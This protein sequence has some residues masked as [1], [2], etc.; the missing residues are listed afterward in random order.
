MPRRFRK[1]PE[2]SIVIV[3]GHGRVYDAD[4]VEGDRYA[5]FAPHLLREIGVP[6]P[7]P[8][9]I[10]VPAPVAA[11][12]FRDALVQATNDTVPIPEEPA[13]ME[14]VAAPSDPP[15]PPKKRGGRPRKVPL[16][17]PAPT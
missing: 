13:T 9:V 17:E 14:Q 8:V 16:P 1:N 15:P 6:E 10:S 11:V 7:A 12:A 4:I 3:P 5:E 2:V